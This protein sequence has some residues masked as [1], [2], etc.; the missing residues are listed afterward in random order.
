M[1]MIYIQNDLLCL[2]KHM[3]SIS[4]SEPILSQFAYFHEQYWARKYLAHSLSQRFSIFFC[5]QRP[6]KLI[7]PCVSLMEKTFP[8]QVYTN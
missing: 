7:N 1:F 5:W 4:T 8:M 6:L 3:F 2:R